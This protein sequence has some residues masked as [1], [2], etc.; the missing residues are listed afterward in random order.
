VKQDVFKSD[1][2]RIGASVGVGGFVHHGVE[3]GEG[4][5][6]GAD[7]FPMMG[8]VVLPGSVWRGDP[9]KIVGSV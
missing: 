8:E 3:L 2:I 1:V 7:A 9:A 4:A 6:L 5:N